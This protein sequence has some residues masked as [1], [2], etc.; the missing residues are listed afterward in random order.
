MRIISDDRQSKTKQ[1]SSYNDFR[2]Y[3]T[4]GDIEFNIVKIYQDFFNGTE[5]FTLFR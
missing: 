2:K 3:L 1:Y 4:F 5:I